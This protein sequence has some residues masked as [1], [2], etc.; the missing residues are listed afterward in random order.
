MFFNISITFRLCKFRYWNWWGINYLFWSITIIWNLTFYVVGVSLKY[1]YYTP[2]LPGLVGFFITQEFELN[3]LLK[4]LRG[5]FSQ[6]GFLVQLCV[7]AVHFP[8]HHPCHF[9]VH[10]CVVLQTSPSKC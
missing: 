7:S 9:G 3:V 8:W 5:Y 4:K 6:P 10:A 1:V 2:G